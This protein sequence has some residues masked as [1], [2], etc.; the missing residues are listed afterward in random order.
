MQVSKIQS[1]LTFQHKILIDIGASN[2]KGTLKISAITDSG[3]QILRERKNSYLNDTVDGFV[4]SKDFIEKIA[5]VIKRTYN[6]VLLKDQSGVFPLS[7]EDKLLSGVTVFVPGT[8]NTMNGRNNGIAFIPNLRDK[9]NSSLTNISFAEY[10]KSLIELPAEETGIKVNKEV[11]NMIVTKDLGGAGV[12][13]AKMLA[14]KNMLHEGDYIMGV[15]TGGGFGSVDIKVKPNAIEFET[16][17]S[18]SYT[19]GNYSVYNKIASLFDTI[20]NSGN[21]VEMFN[22]LIADNNK[23]LKNEIQ[24]LGK[25]GRQGVSVKSHIRAFCEEIGRNDLFK[26]SEMQ[27]L[28]K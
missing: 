28:L 8:T 11:F 25:L 4:D 15:M 7:A 19:S 21:P 12:A 1:G 26:L 9:N 16:S 2:P 17:E 22:E 20:L 3:K 23:K 13:L 14:K 6:R 24:V 5:H 27:E 18:S 10:E